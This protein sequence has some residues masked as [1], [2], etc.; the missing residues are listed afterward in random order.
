MTFSPQEDHELRTLAQHLKERLN[1][2]P[3]GGGAVVKSLA[4]TN[5]YHF[6]ELPLLAV[7]RVSSSGPLLEESQINIVYYVGSMV[8]YSKVEG[9]FNW[10][11]KKIAQY[12]N[13]YGESYECPTILDGLQCEFKLLRLNDATML[14]HVRIFATIRDRHLV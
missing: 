14:P 4:V 11:S 13:E 2:E 3:D 8:D 7:Y 10:V 9:V 1:A 6:K 12:L 5:C